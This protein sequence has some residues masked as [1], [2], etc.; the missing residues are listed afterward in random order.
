MLANE[1]NKGD[2]ASNGVVAFF[3]LSAN[4]AVLYCIGIQFRGRSAPLLAKDSNS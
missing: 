2:D 3:G 4:V 1:F